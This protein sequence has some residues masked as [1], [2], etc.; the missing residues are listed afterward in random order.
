VLIP[1]I[2]GDTPGP[3]TVTSADALGQIG[4]LCGRLHRLAAEYPG[5]GAFQAPGRAGPK[6]APPEQRVAEKR[7]ALL[8]L[9][10]RIAD[11]EIEEELS[12]RVSILDRFGEAL[13]RSRQEVPQG[14]IH[15]DFFCSH[16]VFRE[17]HAVGV[18]DVL[19]E[20]YPPGW[21]LMRAF[22]LSAPS[23]FESPRFEETQWQA[24]VAGY[25]SENPI[26]ARG[27]SQAYDTYLLQLTTS[28]Y[29]LD[30]P[31]D[32]ALRE[33]GRWRTRTA[34]Y[35]AEH[36]QQVRAMMASAVPTVT[37]FSS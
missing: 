29:G 7:A 22:F 34:R 26:T 35:L 17:Q 15:G 25:A 5:A 6:K 19:G 16:V 24:Y 28:T 12:T 11:A 9:A 31:M 33:F 36:R 23:A 18:I 37:S 14:I 32:A 13:S 8:A 21:E 4:A 30:P 27:V 3:N 10:A 2:D 20:H 1:W